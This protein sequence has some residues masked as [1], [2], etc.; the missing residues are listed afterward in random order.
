MGPANVDDACQPFDSGKLVG[1][2]GD[3]SKSTPVTYY[4]QPM[5]FRL[6]P[7]SGESA[8]A[9]L[10]AFRLWMEAATLTTNDEAAGIHSPPLLGQMEAISAQY[11]MP[12]TELIR[13]SPRHSFVFVIFTVLV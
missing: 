1:S 7:A 12:W 6:P 5:M 10:L 4:S 9:Q 2:F 11:Q 13:A 3:F 8:G